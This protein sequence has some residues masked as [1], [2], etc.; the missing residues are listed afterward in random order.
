MRHR[1]R[2]T[3]D[4]ALRRRYFPSASPQPAPDRLL[5]DGDDPG[6]L[7]SGSKRDRVNADLFRAI[8]AYRE[9]V[10]RFKMGDMAGKALHRIAVI[11]TEYLKDPDKGFAAYQELLDRYSQTP[12]RRST[13]CTRWASYY[14]GRK[15]YDKAV[16]SYLRFTYNHP[17]DSRVEAAMLAIAGCHKATKAWGQG[18]RRIS[19]LP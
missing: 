5:W 3:A 19:E 10:D 1:Q 13:H 9:V 16:E 7:A 14:M 12:S 2:L 4:M 6:V 18:P 11:Y 17:S 8:A 15:E